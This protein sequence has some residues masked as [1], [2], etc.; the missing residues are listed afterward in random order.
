MEAGSALIRH[1]LEVALTSWKLARLAIYAGW[2]LY[3]Y[4]CI[5][6]GSF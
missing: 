6:E 2:K 5:S 4:I 3:A 1:V